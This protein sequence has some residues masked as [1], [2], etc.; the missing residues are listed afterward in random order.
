MKDSKS[1]ATTIAPQPWSR[2]QAC[3]DAFGEWRWK[4][5]GERSNPWY[6]SKWYK[7]VCLDILNTKNMILSGCGWSKAFNICTWT[8]SQQEM[9]CVDMLDFCCPLVG[10]PST[11][12]IHKK[13]TLN[14]MSSFYSQIQMCVFQPSNMPK[15]KSRLPSWQ[16]IFIWLVNSRNR[17]MQPKHTK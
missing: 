11:L 14:R 6:L 16:P 7:Y 9:R 2:R 5:S 4:D 1:M 13:H 15:K 17:R 12:V 10:C 3:A 8:N